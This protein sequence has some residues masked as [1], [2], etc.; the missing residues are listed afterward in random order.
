LSVLKSLVLERRLLDH[1]NVTDFRV[2]RVV[3]TAVAMLTLVVTCASAQSD[4]KTTML[5]RGGWDA[6]ARNQPREAAD[7]FREALA[8]DPRNADLY[9]G[10]GT[11]AFLER[12]DA[13]A[14]VALERALEL[15]PALTNA[16]EVLG[17]VL[18]R[19][20]DVLAA[21]R[22]YE[23]LPNAPEYE[24]A[25]LRLERWRRE[26]D[27]LGRMTSV[28]GAWFTVSFEG[29]ADAELAARAL[30][31]IERAA[32][33][34]GLVLSAY[35]L[36]PISVVLYTTEQFRDIT[37]APIWAG[38]AYD[39]TVRVP[40]RGAL[41]NPQE[42]DRVLAHEYTHALV[43]SLAPRNVPAWLHEGLAAA[44]ETDLNQLDGVANSE[45]LPA[46]AL[47]GLQTSFGRFTGDQ[48][49]LAY[50]ASARA[51][52]QLLDEA[53]GFAVANLLRDLGQGVD[54]NQAFLHRI[55][56]P[57]E[58]FEADLSAPR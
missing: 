1:R 22:A 18:Y 14:R 25:R 31:A 8:R 52:R 11:A 44:L 23:R 51:A 26:A 54:F 4:P 53:G 50:D 43:H 17:L 57:F 55:H 39:G 29:E 41:A 13:D 36:Q 42:L 16:R 46:G 47:A 30:A 10:A 21:I 7:A 34:I 12:R 15:N 56:R 2:V 35:P 48:A 5:E 9:L 24:P 27:L 3:M 20:G 49:R 19:S 6:L 40:M 37:K 45:P 58:S 28:A 38:G 32:D 33:R